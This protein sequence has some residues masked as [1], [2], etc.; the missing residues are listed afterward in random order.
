MCSLLNLRLA[1]QSGGKVQLIPPILSITWNHIFTGHLTFLVKCIKCTDTLTASQNGLSFSSRVFVPFGVIVMLLNWLQLFTDFSFM[2]V[3]AAEISR[4]WPGTQPQGDYQGKNCPESL[5]GC[6]HVLTDFIWGEGNASSYRWVSSVTLQLNYQLFRFWM[7]K[8]YKPG[9]MPFGTSLK[10]RQAPHTNPPYVHCHSI[11][12]D[13][14]KAPYRT[15]IL[16][17]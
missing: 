6:R 5:N 12:P 14:S 13:I 10:A 17:Q 16:W 11:H 9:H 3:F 15:H 1:A 2:V 7:W 8:H 4:H